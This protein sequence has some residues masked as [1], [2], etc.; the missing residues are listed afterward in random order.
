LN[1]ATSRAR[2]AAVVVAS[3]ALVRV[4]CHTPRQMQLANALCRFVELA[5]GNASI[6]ASTAAPGAQTLA[7]A[8]TDAMPLQLS[9]L[10]EGS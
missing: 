1:V 6:P 2:C 3:P 4:A 7:E 8:A 9:W 10:G 5:G